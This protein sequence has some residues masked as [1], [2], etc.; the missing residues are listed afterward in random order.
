MKKS[1]ESKKT[2]KRRKGRLRKVERKRQ[3]SGRLHV[4]GERPE[5]AGAERVNTL[6]PL[7]AEL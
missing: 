4:L 5:H 3:K 2:D 1:E 6:Y 7:T